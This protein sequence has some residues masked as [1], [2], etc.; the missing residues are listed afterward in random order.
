MALLTAFGAGLWLSALNVRYRDVRYI[1]PFGTQIWFFL[2]PV[3]YGVSIVPLRYHWII[4]MNP[5]TGVVDGF[6]WAVLGRGL[7]EYRLYAISL[8][9]GIVLTISGLFYFKHVERTF[10]DV[11]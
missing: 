1:V 5:M 6:R 11:I 3:I 10:A 7:P 4:A 2:T 8:A 9:V